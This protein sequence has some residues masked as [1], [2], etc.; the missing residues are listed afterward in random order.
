MRFLRKADANALFILSNLEMR[1]LRKS[2]LTNLLYLVQEFFQ[3]LAD[4]LLRE[5]LYLQALLMR[6]VNPKSRYECVAF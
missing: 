1:S 6:C 3:N 5:F 4:F 2:N